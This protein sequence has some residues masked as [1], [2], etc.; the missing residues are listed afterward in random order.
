MLRGCARYKLVV[1]LSTMA[2]VIPYAF[3]ALSVGLVAARSGRSG[4]PMPRVG[5]IGVIAFVFSLFTVYGCGSTAVLY[6]LILLLLG[7]PVY[8]RQRRL[9]LKG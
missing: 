2:A 3:C 1:S 8:V 5:V 7:F 6:G 9:T 4:T